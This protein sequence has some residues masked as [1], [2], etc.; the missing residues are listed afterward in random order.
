MRI[1]HRIFSE[2]RIHE[3]ES[4]DMETLR[5]SPIH[6]SLYNHVL[7]DTHLNK[8]DGYFNELKISTD[9]MAS[10]QA[11]HHGKAV[12]ICGQ[13]KVAILRKRRGYVHA[14]M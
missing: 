14:A 5:S 3:I 1:S 10:A 4:G 7:D 9:S 11:T 8:T 2:V 12:A 13:L 6:L